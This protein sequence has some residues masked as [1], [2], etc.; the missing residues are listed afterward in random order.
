MVT[1]K[2]IALALGVTEEEL[3]AKLAPASFDVANQLGQL[4][5]VRSEL[6]QLSNQATQ[7]TTQT[8]QL[9]AAYLKLQAIATESGGAKALQA[10]WLES[11]GTARKQA[12]S[13]TAEGRELAASF[14]Q[15]VL[16]E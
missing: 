3:R 11:V 13:L 6:T 1:A 14:F 10:R 15:A 4:I 9:V 8:V 7:L 5:D 12:T 2:E 16:A